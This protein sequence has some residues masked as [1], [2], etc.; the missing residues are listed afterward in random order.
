MRSKQ[1]TIIWKAACWTSFLCHFVW[2]YIFCYPPE[3]ATRNIGKMANHEDGFFFSSGRF[4]RGIDSS[5]ISD[6]MQVGLYK[7][8]GTFKFKRKNTAIEK[9]STT[10][11]M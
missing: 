11:T 5:F 7:M 10:T 9:G 6:L 2:F 3:K 8:L 4:N 1:C